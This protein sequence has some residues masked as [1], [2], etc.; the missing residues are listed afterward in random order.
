[1]AVSLSC[2]VFQDPVGFESTSQLVLIISLNLDLSE[3]F[4]R[5]NW[6][7]GLGEEH[8]KCEI[9]FSLYQ[10]GCIHIYSSCYC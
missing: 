2:P 3:I 7:Y 5:Y 10:T 9:P 8:H 4:S 1:M 6:E